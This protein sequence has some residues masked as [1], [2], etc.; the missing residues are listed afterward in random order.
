MRM[1]RFSAVISRKR[2]EEEPSMR[3]KTQFSG[4]GSQRSLL[5]ACRRI[6]RSAYH[7][8]SGFAVILPVAMANGPLP[9]HASQCGDAIATLE[10]AERDLNTG[11]HAP[12]SIGAQLH[13]Q[14]TPGSIAN[15]ESRARKRKSDGALAAARKLHAQ[16]KEAECIA[17]LL[18]AGIV[19]DD[20][21]A[22]PEIF[23]DCK[24]LREGS[25]GF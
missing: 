20:R 19:P 5:S 8:V 15:A 17:T 4:C 6:A 2:K 12:Q 3:G 7:G 22:L 25:R 24:C 18:K 23:R 16:G 13:H 10:S 11:P 21:G 1:S 14:P 9:A